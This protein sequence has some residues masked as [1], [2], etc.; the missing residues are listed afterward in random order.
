MSKLIKITAEDCVLTVMAYTRRLRP[1]G[2]PF[3][4]YRY[5]KGCGINFII[6]EVLDK[7]V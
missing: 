4:G 1:K 7:G 5:M 2:V 3:T 6:T